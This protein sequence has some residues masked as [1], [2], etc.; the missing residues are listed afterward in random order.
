MDRTRGRQ[1]RSWTGQELDRPEVRQTGVG[2]DRSWTGQKLGRTGVG[3][4]RS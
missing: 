3:Q 4:G 1:D 2:Q